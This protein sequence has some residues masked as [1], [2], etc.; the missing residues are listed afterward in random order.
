MW[1][2][3]Y[4]QHYFVLKNVHVDYNGVVPRK[5]FEV[6]NEYALQN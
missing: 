5:N 1:N 4:F 6:Y 3:Y 2:Q